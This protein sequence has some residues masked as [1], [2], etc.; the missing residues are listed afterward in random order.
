MPADR[1]VFLELINDVIYLFRLEER[2]GEFGGRI[3][4][5]NKR[6]KDITGYEPEDFMRDVSLWMSL[7]HPEDRGRLVR[8]ALEFLKKKKSG[9]REYRVRNAE[10]RYVWIED[11]VIPITE[12]GKVIGFLGVGRDITKRKVL[13]ELSFLALRSSPEELMDRAVE[14]VADALG[15]DVVVVYEVS[16]DSGEGVLKAGKGVKKQLLGKYRQPL[17]E[18]TE[19]YYTYTSSSPVIVKDVAKEKKFKINPDAYSLG[20]KSG[21]CIPIRSGGKPYGTLCIYTKKRRSFSKEDVSFAQSVA[22]ILGL[23]IERGRHERELDRVGRLYRTLYAINGIILRE[24]DR[25]KLL[26]EVCRAINLYAGFRG[27]WTAVLENSKIKTVCSCGDVE[28]FLREVELPLMERIHEGQGPSGRAFVSGE[29]VINN[30][31]DKEVEPP[32]LREEMLKRGYL[33]SASVPIKHGEKVVAL[34]VLYA[35]ERG[36]FDRETINLINGIGKELSFAMDFLEKEEKLKW[37]SVAL[38]QTSDWVLIT[39]DKGTILYANG[40]VERIS[41]Y[42]V[43]ELIGKKSSVFKSGEHDDAFYRDLWERITSGK[44]FRSVF[45][46]RKKTG[47]LYYLDQTITPIRDEKGKVIGFVATGKDITRERELRIKLVDLALRD[48]LTGLPNRRDFLEKLSFLLS[49]AKFSRRLV[50]LCLLDID[51]FKYIND[52]FGF[53]VGDSLLREVARRLRENLRSSDVVSR[54]GG[55][56]FVIALT[57][58]EKRED[59][60]RILRKVLGTFEKPFGEG[61]NLSVSVGISLFPDDGRDPEELL[62]KAELAMS[63]AKESASN[64]YQFFREELNVS[65]SQFLLMEKLLRTALEK[66]EYTLLFQPCLYLKDRKLHAFEALLRWRSKDLGL[67]PPSKFVPVLEKTGLI[68]DVGMW[69]AEEVCGKIARWRVP[70]SINVSPVQFKS[71]EFGK[72]LKDIVEK[73]KIEGSYLII[74]ITESSAME[75]V[76]FTISVLRELKGKGINVAIDDF[77]TGYSSLAYLKLLP[78]DFLKIDTSFIRNIDTDPDD[79]T[80]VRAIVQLAKSLGLKTVAEGIEK[81]EHLNILKDMGCELGQGYLFS[82]PLPEEEARRLL[83][84]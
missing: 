60:P 52:V 73:H 46:N 10:G 29:V 31:T 22:D 83:G 71:D 14:W 57:D 79:R 59:I 43:S 75:D 30:D 55:D 35:S 66:G 25:E 19:F 37:F 47:E 21:M 36:F 11:R 76:D 54:L 64:T 72:A 8:S 82:K 65:V 56:E 3:T 61:I 38:E 49:R 15:A 23:A 80:I 58:V 51:R 33:S 44:T 32:F 34:L 26:R 48:P 45:I 74:E 81:E 69:V 12:R 28:E 77:G 1:G 53:R 18:G 84:I 41:G 68:E 67:V 17:K 50:V 63:H 78:A 70:M 16:E 7:V 42:G 6:I 40:A 2:E 5:I 24:R 27:V 4:Y 13:A 39:D 62:R 20:L 9:T